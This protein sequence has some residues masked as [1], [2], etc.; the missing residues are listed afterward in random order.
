MNKLLALVFAL[1]FGMSI[2]A[3]V[4][5]KTDTALKPDISPKANVL[6]KTS[7]GNI[8][9]ELDSVAAP[10]T[11]RN[12]LQYVDE[13]FYNNTVFH[14]VIANFM[15]QGGGFDPGMQEKAT[16]AP[17]KNES[18]NG[19]KNIRGSIAMARTQNPDSASA[20]FFINLV[21]N[22]YLDGSPVKPG[23]AVFG[24]VT[25]GMDI[26]D[27]IGSAETASRGMHQDVPVQDILIITASRIETG[28]AD[29]K[30]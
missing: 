9:L 14:R 8:V 5:D 24:K 10:E 16:R 12:F 3:D 17:I 22:A 6:L 26:I 1:L 13:G 19:L 11:T 27:K 4:A 18:S 23:Y 20:Q 28:T 25:Q 29:P 30:P 15:V 21:D 7:L 2:A